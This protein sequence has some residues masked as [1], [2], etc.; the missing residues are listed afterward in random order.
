MV[1][2]STTV[3][4]VITYSPIWYTIIDSG[5]QR[6]IFSNRELLY[7]FVKNKD[8]VKTGSG[9]ILTSPGHGTI[10]FKLD[11]PDS[12]IPQRIHNAIQCPDLGYNL[13]GTL[14]LARSNI[15]VQ[16]KPIS[17]PS[18]LL[19][20]NKCFGYANIINNQYALRGRCIERNAIRACTV[21][22]L[23]VQPS[24]II[25]PELLHRR[26]GHLNQNSV[27]QVPKHSTGIEI[28]GKKPEDVYGSCI[29]G[30]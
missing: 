23:A 13:I 5:A 24:T 20:D 11:S 14:P 18:K 30:Y 4:R 16:L 25:N 26:I 6:V 19:S 15:K 3:N 22:A 21:E 2:N 27:I 29:K 8:F 17:Q 28:Q 12:V 9:K 10:I 1:K 7:N